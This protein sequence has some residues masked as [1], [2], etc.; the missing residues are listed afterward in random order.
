MVKHKTH[1]PIGCSEGGG[2]ESF[3]L[4][5]P[6]KCGVTLLAST[7]PTVRTVVCT[8]AILRGDS[9]RVSSSVVQRA[10][11]FLKN[12][13]EGRAYIVRAVPA[14]RHVLRKV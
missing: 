7:P 11:V 6:I 4:R 9:V 2:I 3:L 5:R 14:S 10:W 8:T 13:V 1:S 12:P